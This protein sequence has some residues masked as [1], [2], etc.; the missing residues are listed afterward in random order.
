MG[1]IGWCT[2][3]QAGEGVILGGNKQPVPLIFQGLEKADA[4]NM[5]KAFGTVLEKMTGQ[6]PATT[7]LP[8][9]AE[10]PA[11]SLVV[12]LVPDLKAS[13]DAF[14]IRTEGGR[15]VITSGGVMGLRF[16]FYEFMERLGC[17]FWAWD[18]ETIPSQPEIHVPPLEVFWIPPFIIHDLMNQE[19]MTRDNDFAYKLLGISSLQFTGNHNLQPMLRNFADAHPKEVFPLVKTRDKATGKVTKEVREFNNLH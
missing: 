13:D 6:P 8:A 5:G 19:A 4:A 10:P 1:I 18:E 9:G 3:S 16:G 2:P 15:V 14:Q 17:R 12:R 7:D 11:N